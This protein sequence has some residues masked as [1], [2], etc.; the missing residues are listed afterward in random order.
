MSIGY[1][2][3]LFLK[4]RKVTLPCSC[5]GQIKSGMLFSIGKRAY[6]RHNGRKFM[7]TE[8][9][10]LKVSAHPITSSKG[11]QM[12]LHVPSLTDV[13]RQVVGCDEQ[14]RFQRFN[15][16]SI[17]TYITMVCFC[18]IMILQGRFLIIV[19]TDNT[20]LSVIE[21]KLLTTNWKVASRLT[22]RQLPAFTVAP[23]RV[24]SVAALSVVRTVVGTPAAA[25][26][27]V[28]FLG[29]DILSTYS[30]SH[31]MISYI[32][33]PG[34]T[35]TRKHSTGVTGQTCQGRD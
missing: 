25:A 15:S 18:M 26:K 9:N 23:L 11:L 35:V 34:D 33:K 19:G 29:S 13:V 21:L 27:V 7:K 6:L 5:R 12:W 3:C 14:C 24:V 31:T 22:S 32:S 30:S 16:I 1:L 4:G 10:P 2:V 8:K 20:A 28:S 17:I